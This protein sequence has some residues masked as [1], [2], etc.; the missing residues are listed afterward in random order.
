VSGFGFG[1]AT[2]D[3]ST[4]SE[5]AQGDFA[6]PT[7]LR[8]APSQPAELARQMR[9]ALVAGRTD[10]NH[11][12]DH[13]PA[14]ADLIIRRL[15][16]QDHAVLERDAFV[17]RTERRKLVHIDADAVAAIAAP[18]RGQRALPHPLDRADEVTEW[19]FFAALRS[20]ANGT[21]RT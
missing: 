1:S 20:V 9:Q 10:D 4:V 3:S 17:C 5:A 8:R 21:K 16:T 7:A 2:A 18:V 19:R 12:L 6:H 13:H 14:P 15:Q 11:V